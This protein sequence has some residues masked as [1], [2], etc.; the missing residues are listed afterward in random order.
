[1]E[2]TPLSIIA[3]H[4]SA[5]FWDGV[6][7]TVYV[8]WLCAVPAGRTCS[9]AVPLFDSPHMTSVVAVPDG[10]AVSWKGPS[11]PPVLKTH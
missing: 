10:V 4:E 3:D 6:Q 5:R 2:N 8:A 9:V 11:V 7:W 1:V